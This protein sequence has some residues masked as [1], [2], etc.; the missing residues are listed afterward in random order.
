MSWLALEYGIED[1]SRL[2]EGFMFYVYDMLDNC[3]YDSLHYV[4][5]NRL[6][7]IRLFGGCYLVSQLDGLSLCALARIFL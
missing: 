7:Y 3:Y 1:I 6:M 4:V 2:G 5:G